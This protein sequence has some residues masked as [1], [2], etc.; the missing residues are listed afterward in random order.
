MIPAAALS[1]RIARLE[2]LLRGLA[3]EV[4]LWRSGDDP[5]LYLERLEYLDAIQHALA[6]VEAARVVLTRA[7]MR[8]DGDTPDG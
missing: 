3:H 5:L 8:L 7:R 4:Q 2:Q 6:G 1:R